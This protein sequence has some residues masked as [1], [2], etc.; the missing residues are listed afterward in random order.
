V[1]LPEKWMKYR[2]PGGIS[3]YV[4]ISITKKRPTELRNTEELLIC[5]CCLPPPPPP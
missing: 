4:D 2:A 5:D 1:V 3:L